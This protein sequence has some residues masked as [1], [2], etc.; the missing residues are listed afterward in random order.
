MKKFSKKNL[1]FAACGSA[2]ILSGCASPAVAPRP[3]FDPDDEV[4][5]SGITTRDI[6]TVATQMAPSLLAVPEIANGDGSK[7]VKI[8]EFKNS[9]RFFV[10][11]SLFIKRLSVELNRHGNG[12]VRFLNNNAQVIQDRMD[13]MKDR[14][15][16]QILKNLK[17]IA[18]EI[19]ALPAAR[20]GKP[21]TV[22][23]LPVLNINLVNMNGESFIAMLRSE[24]SAASQG[25]V[26]FLLPGT[27]VDKADYYLAGQF[28]P[29]T[30]KTEG[31]INLANYIEVVDARVKSGRSMYV[32]STIE[33]DV[34]PG[35]V[36]TV[37]HNSSLH[38]TTV[39]PTY[40]KQ[41]ITVYENHI[42][43]LLN[44]PQLR[45]A[46]DINKRLN[47]IL[48]DARTKA[49]IY[50]KMVL[51]DRKVTSGIGHADYVIS[52]EITG[53]YERN[54]KTTSDYLLITMQ[55]TDVETGEI[56]WEDACEIK[57]KVDPEARYN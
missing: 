26:Q 12:K 8:S 5:V 48:A 30:I 18:A 27:P 21:I 33:S 54:S 57:R 37:A 29:E 2:I 16:A 25:R 1:L 15:S 45:S 39:T 36:T 38:S 28:I 13:A 46:P 47:V 42:K 9:S 14:Q 23:V 44:N 22:A 41:K 55:L 11:R 19:A 20:Q 4:I 10:D 17:Q 34:V 24:V 52:G 31:I 6:R 50:E 40:E 53:M 3:D 51:I 35:Q 32:T 56:L 43:D 49:S 7:R